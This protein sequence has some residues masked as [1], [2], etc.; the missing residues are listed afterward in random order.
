MFSYLTILLHICAQLLFQPLAYVLY[1]VW[2]II[3]HFAGCLKIDIHVIIL[4][5][6]FDA[7]TD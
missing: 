6:V 4:R 5:G 7:I 1:A 2:F 3:P